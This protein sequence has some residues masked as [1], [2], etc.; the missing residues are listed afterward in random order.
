MF[1]WNAWQ[2]ALVWRDMHDRKSA[3]SANCAK[4]W[5]IFSLNVHSVLN[6]TS[7]FRRKLN[8]SA[9]ITNFSICLPLS[10]WF[11]ANIILSL[12]RT[13]YRL[14]QHSIMNGPAESVSKMQSNLDLLLVSQRW[15]FM[16]D[17]KSNYISIYYNIAS[18]WENR[19]HSNTVGLERC[20]RIRSI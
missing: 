6:D 8:N 17:F 13:F 16:C 18:S 9:H 19:S 11:L 20:N 10:R 2:C 1:N 4:T 14:F 5:T 3:T 15:N 12:N 7:I